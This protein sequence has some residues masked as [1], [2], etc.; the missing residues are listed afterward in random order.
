MV[1]KNF[2]FDFPLKIS[3]NKNIDCYKA[4]TDTTRIISPDCYKSNFTETI[5]KPLSK[6]YSDVL[7]NNSVTNRQ[8]LGCLKKVADVLGNSTVNTT[9]FINSDVE[10]AVAQQ[11]P[12]NQAT[13]TFVTQIL[14]VL[15][16]RRKYL[17]TTSDIF[18]QSFSGND[19][20]GYATGFVY[21][22]SEQSQII[23]AFKVYANFIYNFFSNLST[24]VSNVQGLIGSLDQCR[25]PANFTNTTSSKRLLQGKKHI[26]NLRFYYIFLLKFSF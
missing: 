2:L 25:P 3:I 8:G 14:T 6:G 10:A 18:V 5:R 16:A 26:F 17:L 12:F 20:S 22:T 13:A 19:S 7:T 1:L 23:S 24:K 4:N 15:N 11:I 21:T 9:S